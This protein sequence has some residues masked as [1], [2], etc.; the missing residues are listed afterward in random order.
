MTI[1]KGTISTSIYFENEFSDSGIMVGHASNSEISISDITITGSTTFK[2][3]S[4]RSGM[5][6]N[7]DSNS[8]IHI[9]N[10]N[11]GLSSSY[12]SMTYNGQGSNIGVIG[13]LYESTIEFTHST[14]YY[15]LNATK[16]DQTGFLGYAYTGGSTKKFYNFTSLSI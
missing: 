6:G 8:I 12:Y 2:N 5:L 3:S 14:M 16:A 7:I 4:S 11:A 1:S 15:N 10:V 9:T 13:Q